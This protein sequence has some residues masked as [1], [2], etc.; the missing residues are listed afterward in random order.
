MKMLQIIGLASLFVCPL[1][2]PNLH[3]QTSFAIVTGSYNNSQWCERNLTLLFEQDYNN[4]HL[5]YIDDYSQDDTFDKVESLIRKY[6]KAD[7]VTLIRNKKRYG[8]MYNQYT[9]I[10][11][12]DPQ[13]VVV[14]YDGDDWFAH[15][16]V[17]HRL[18]EE[19]TSGDVWLTYGQFWYWSKNRLG[20]CRKLPEATIKNN[21]FREHPIWVTSHIRTF[22]A[23][24]FQRIKLED[25]LY[26]GDFM[27]MSVDVATMFPMLEMA[28][29]H[30]RF[31]ED[32]LYV[33]N[34]ANQLNFFHDHKERQALIRKE[35]ASRPKYKPLP[36]L[37]ES[38]PI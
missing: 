35:L 31:I 21:L 12:I 15:T 26:N 9:V 16:H 1:Y 10:N 7:K 2:A 33:Y 11:K 27:P 20:I 6:N 37:L 14:I 32:V 3:E 23:A 24:L 13:S 38:A 4:W 8:H 5:F 17:L 29:E 25:L 19:Y 30:I 36:R 18:N 28:G 34:D 22:Y